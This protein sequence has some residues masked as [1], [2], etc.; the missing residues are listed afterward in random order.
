M[1]LLR[2]SFQVYL[3]SEKETVLSGSTVSGPR[4]GMCSSQL[5]MNGSTI[6]AAGKGCKNGHGIGNGTQVY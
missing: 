5:L 3:L 2:E 6:D 1:P 4:I